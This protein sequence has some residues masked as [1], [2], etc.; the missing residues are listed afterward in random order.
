MRKLFLM[1][2]ALFLMH[3]GMQAKVRLPHVL[4]DNMVIQQ[5]ADVRLWGS[6]K[7][8]STVK[9]SVSW[10]GDAYSAKADSKGEWQ[11]A[12]ESTGSS[13]YFFRFSFV[14]Q[15]STFEPPLLAMIRPTGTL[16]M[17]LGKAVA[18]RLRL[19]RDTVLLRSDSTLRLRKR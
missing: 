5:D 6:A 17:R 14:S 8:N 18:R 3:A 9:V 4:G 19:R 7:P 11:L 2:S 15:L 13:V 16:S 1:I 12:C 10:S